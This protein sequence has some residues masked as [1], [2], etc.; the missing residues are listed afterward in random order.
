MSGIFAQNLHH[1]F[2]KSAK[3]KLP[4]LGIETHNTKTSIRILTASP[5][6]PI[7]QSMPV[8][9]FQTLIKSCSIEPEMTQVQ[10][11]DLLFNKCLCG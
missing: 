9:D 10:F 6:Q 5:T 4:P 11:K 1:G 7:C 8:S 2:S 3:I